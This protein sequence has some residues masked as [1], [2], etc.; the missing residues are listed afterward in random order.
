[1]LFY[2]VCEKELLKWDPFP[3]FFSTYRCAR[4]SE[5][6]LARFRVFANDS[7]LYSE[8]DNTCHSL[9]ESKFGILGWCGSATLQRKGVCWIYTRQNESIISSLQN[10]MQRN[11][12]FIFFS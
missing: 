8:L 6:Q 9:A 11:N 7:L 5:R 12:P 4:N 10:G 3:F 1:M 2:F